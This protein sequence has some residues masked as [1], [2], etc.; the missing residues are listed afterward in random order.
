LS[1]SNF[2]ASH[3]AAHSGT[4]RT[5]PFPIAE[6][7]EAAIAGAVTKKKEKSTPS[8]MMAGAPGPYC[9]SFEVDDEGDSGD[10]DD[11]DS[12][13]DVEEEAA[14]EYICCGRGCRNSISG[15]CFEKSLR[16]FQDLARLS[17][18]PD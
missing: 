7:Q 11:D 9:Y 10:D 12:E 2:A 6:V 8:D 18:M 5:L 3:D 13:D 17:C 4:R 16:S 14:V 15:S 1:G